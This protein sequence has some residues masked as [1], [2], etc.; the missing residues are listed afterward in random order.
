MTGANTI[1]DVLDTTPLE[2][3]PEPGTAE[4]RIEV[5][6]D[7]RAFLAL[8][9]VWNEV[10]EA[11]GVAHPFL[12]YLWV[13]TWWESFG[14]GSTLHILVLKAG[15]RPIAIAPLMLTPI[16]MWGMPV[17][18]LGFLYNAH[19]P[20]ADFLIAERHVEVYRAIWAHVSRS[21]CWDLLQ[22][23]QLPDGG[24]TLEGMAWLAAEAG[25]YTG[26]WT[27]DSSPYLRI[28][29]SWDEYFEGLAAKHRSN[30]RNRFKRLKAM[31]PVGV[32]TI[33]SAEGLADG[34]EDGL[35][36]EAAAWKGEAQTAIACDPAVARFYSTLAERAAERG[37]LRL[38]FL[39]AG[40]ARVAF[41][42]SLS[43]KNRIHLLKVGYDPAFAPL[44]PSNLLLCRILQNAFEQ[45][46]T[47]YDFLGADAD[48]KLSW[49]KQ[50]K[51]YCWLFIF[52]GTFKGRCLH[53]IKFQLIPLLK[54]PGF[55]LLRGLV[56]R[57]A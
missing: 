17:R 31:G 30:L 6:S 20:R 45:G 50:L 52:P 7:L 18:R 34:V 5:I 32:E 22:L 46:V 27:S 43:Y 49:T 57:G 39:H 51:R 54:R 15:G 12:E 42:Y 29:P 21:R 9:S 14:A 16:P 44:S 56:R 1:T 36:L 8:E 23:C 25:C 55:R 47:E 33:D 19:V 10:A 41:D 3:R 24:A 35:R 40:E 11:A 48:W 38:H 13:R 2:T 37:W 28:G 26:R 4:I 53:L